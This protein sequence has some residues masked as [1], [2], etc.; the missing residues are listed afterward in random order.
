MMTLRNLLCGASGCVP[1]PAIQLVQPMRRDLGVG[2][3][4]KHICR[5]F[6]PNRH[7]WQAY[8][9]PSCGGSHAAPH[10]P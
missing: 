10:Q 4:E 3:Q 8:P 2:M 7:S 6:S 5:K 1:K 9:M